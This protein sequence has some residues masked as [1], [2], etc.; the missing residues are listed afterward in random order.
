MRLLLRLVFSVSV[1]VLIFATS[2]FSQTD[3]GTITGTVADASS[4]VIPGANVTAT[5]S[6]TTAKYET[7]S[8]ETGNYTLTQLPAGTYE[9]TVELPGFKK[10]VRQGVTVLAATVVRFNR[11]R[12]PSATASFI[13]T[14]AK[15]TRTYVDPADPTKTFNV[16]ADSNG[17]VDTKVAGGF[18][19]VNTSSAPST[20]ASRQGQ[21]VARISF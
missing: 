2:L 17:H 11:S 13:T 4:A 21:I 15:A 1:C 7:V 18:G 14:N 16:P 20:P 19:F 5:N 6:Q 9:V 10:Y 8:T 12:L 3:R